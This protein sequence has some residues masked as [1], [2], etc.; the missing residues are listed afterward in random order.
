[1]IIF[2]ASGKLFVYV[3]LVCLIHIDVQLIDIKTQYL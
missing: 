1:M 2:V 3:F